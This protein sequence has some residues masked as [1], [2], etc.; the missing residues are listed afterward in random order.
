M[1][2]SRQFMAPYGALIEELFEHPAMRTAL[3][4]LSAQSGP[5]PSEMASGDMLG[6]NAMIHKSGAKRAKGGS[7][8]LTQAM[9]KCLLSAW[10]GDHLQRGGS[11]NHASEAVEGYLPKGLGGGRRWSK[12]RSVAQETGAAAGEN[13]HLESYG[14]PRR[15]RH[16]SP[17]SLQ[18]APRGLDPNLKSASPA[19]ASATASA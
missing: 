8:A 3:A 9:A 14:Q 2:T 5:A 7:G 11:R 19:P 12:R 6:W 17:H 15:L 16:P 10:R 1:D 13:G 18:N 4:W